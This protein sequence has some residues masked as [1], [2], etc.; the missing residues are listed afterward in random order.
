MESKSEEHAT[1]SSVN[2]SV[3]SVNEEREEEFTE[4]ETKKA[5]EYKTKGNEAFKSSIALL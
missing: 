1:E 5:E 4:E 3:G 2:T